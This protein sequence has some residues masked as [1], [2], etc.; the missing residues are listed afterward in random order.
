MKKVLIFSLAIFFLG[1]ILKFLHVH[2]N[3]IFMLVGLS[4]VFIS[5]VVLSLQKKLRP[6]ESLVG[7]ASFSWLLLLV[8]SLKYFP[9]SGYVFFAAFALS[10]LTVSYAFYN[11]SVGQLY[12]LL[13]SAVLAATFYYM[14]T[15][16][17]YYITSI[18][19]NYEVSTDYPTWDK[20]SW[21]LYQNEAFE[22]AE[23]AS[24]NALQ[25]AITAEDQEWIDRIIEHQHWIV[26]QSWDSYYRRDE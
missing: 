20:Y 18:K 3:L 14:R 4:L 22:E 9:H 16:V 7:F 8:F 12:L 25:M 13:L 2:Y 21:F 1:F 10:L 17:R 15:D 23:K 26:T 6:I 24:E 11:K 19:W 5:L